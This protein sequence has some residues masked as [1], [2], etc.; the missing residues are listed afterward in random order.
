MT[1]HMPSNY[2]RRLIV[3]LYGTMLLI[4]QTL[5]HK[6]HVF[7]WLCPFTNA[8]DST[9][10]EGVDRTV[11]FSCKASCMVSYGAVI[12]RKSWKFSHP[13]A[14]LTACVWSGG[15]VARILN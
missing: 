3:T 15:A 6:S 10:S 2:I 8:C 7:F 13:C 11:E 4:P 9:I 12:H 5:I 14:R 1:I